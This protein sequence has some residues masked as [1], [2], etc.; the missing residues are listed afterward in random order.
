ME[1]EHVVGLAVL[2]LPPVLQQEVVRGEEDHQDENEINLHG[3]SCIITM[4][5]LNG[6][7]CVVQLLIFTQM[8]DI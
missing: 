2:R 4:I 7:V 1:E 3:D 6:P 8:I 5:L